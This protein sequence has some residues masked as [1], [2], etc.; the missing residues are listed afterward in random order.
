MIF[1]TG[2]FNVIL[3]NKSKFGNTNLKLVTANYFPKGEV[4][5]GLNCNLF[6]GKICL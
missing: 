4:Y 1:S 2:R 3:R 5:N 6:F